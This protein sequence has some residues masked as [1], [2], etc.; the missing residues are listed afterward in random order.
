MI[1]SLR[2]VCKLYLVGSLPPKSPCLGGRVTFFF[3]ITEVNSIG[4]RGIGL[5]AAVGLRVHTGNGDVGLGSGRVRRGRG[6]GRSGFWCRERRD[7]ES[8]RQ[9]EEKAKHA[10]GCLGWYELEQ[11]RLG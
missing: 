7:V 3:D 9:H 1:K 11:V 10:E 5:R 6:A 4:Y 8:F 2:A